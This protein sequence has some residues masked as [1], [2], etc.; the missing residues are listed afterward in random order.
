MNIDMTFETR[1]KYARRDA[2]KE[3]IQ[4]GRKE[5]IQLGR[6]EG[7]IAFAKAYKKGMI[8]KEDVLS[9]LDITEEEFDELVCEY[10]ASAGEE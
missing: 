10:E 9:L 3:G 7:E 1:E 8:S 6:K 4:L 2:L 5:G